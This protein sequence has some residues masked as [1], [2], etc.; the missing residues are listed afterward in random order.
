MGLNY[1]DYLDVNPSIKTGLGGKRE[2]YE[3]VSVEQHSFLACS[4][5]AGALPEQRLQ[6]HSTREPSPLE[7]SGGGKREKK[8][9][10]E[11]L[12]HLLL[13]KQIFESLILY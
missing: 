12:F 8:F 4:G 1:I 13:L 6:W 3:K 10:L 5:S 11:I 9:V 2:M 7:N